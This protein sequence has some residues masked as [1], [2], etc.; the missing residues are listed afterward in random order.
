MDSIFGNIVYNEY[1]AGS[2]KGNVGIGDVFNTPFALPQTHNADGNYTAGMV[3]ATN[4]PTPAAASNTVTI[5]LK[6]SKVLPNSVLLHTRVSTQDY[7][8]FD[9][10]A[11]KIYVSETAPATERTISAANGGSVTYA[12]RDVT[13]LTQAGTIDYGSFRDATQGASIPGS[14]ALDVTT[15]TGGA[16]GK[17]GTTF[18]LEYYYDNVYVPQN[19]LPILNVRK[20]RIAVEAKVRRIAIN[21]AQLAAYQNST[22]YGEDLQSELTKQAV[23]QLKY[24]IDVEAVQ[25]LLDLAKQAGA[26]AGN[27]AGIGSNKLVWDRTLPIGVSK[28]EHYAGFAEVLAQA[29]QAIY[30]RTRKFMANFAVVASDLVPILD[31]VPGF[32]KAST[33]NINGPYYAGNANGLKVYVTPSFGAGQ[34][35][36]GLN[37]GKLEGSAAALC[38]Y[39][40]VAPTQLLGFAD[41]TMSQGFATAYA[42]VGLNKYLVVE[43]LVTG[44]SNSYWAQNGVGTALHTSTSA[45]S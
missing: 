16:D 6:W 36:V 19:D 13:G 42:I 2:N 11:G 28:Q 32:Q 21:Y 26:E 43:G 12:Q 5:P 4:K 30:D 15:S 22:D 8:F 17:V 27:I 29:S 45:I 37:A 33:N 18:D 44:T 9:D 24:D 25:T 39:M 38:M 1:V 14:I 41:G 23:G 35:V 34:F 3:T 7:Y 31:F 10:G 40:P 20:N